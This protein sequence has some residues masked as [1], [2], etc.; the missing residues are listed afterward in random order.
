LT[1][2]PAPNPAPQPTAD[3]ILKKTGSRSGIGLVTIR[4]LLG[5]GARGVTC[6]LGADRLN[7]AIGELGQKLEDP[8]LAPSI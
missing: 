4:I 3:A 7:A 1:E 8:T 6:D 5:E 2:I